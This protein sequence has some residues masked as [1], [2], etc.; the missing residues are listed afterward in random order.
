M[1]W[2]CP[3]HFD[4][5]SAASSLP[6][7][8]QTLPTPRMHRSLKSFEEAEEERDWKIEKHR[9]DKQ[10]TFLKLTECCAW[11]QL[12]HVFI[13]IW[14]LTGHKVHVIYLHTQPT[15]HTHYSVSYLLCKTLEQLF[16][17]WG[18]VSVQ[19]AK[20]AQ[21]APDHL[22]SQTIK[23]RKLIK[24]QRVDCPGKKEEEMLKS[25]KTSVCVTP[26]QKMWNPILG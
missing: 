15:L 10:Q 6:L 8:L 18:E 5:K 4:T 25:V 13:L 22:Q 23:L 14:S 20:C 16:H 17:V 2:V 11:N 12:A 24:E 21:H 1:H 9:E 19:T 26:L 3:P 7:T